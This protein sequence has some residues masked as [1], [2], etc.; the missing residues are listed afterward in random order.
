MDVVVSG[1][2]GFI[3][4][5]LVPALVA[6]GHRARRLVRGTAGEGEVA[7]DPDA[8]TIDVAALEGVEG[9]VHLGGVGIGDKRWTPE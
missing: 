9:V 1:S 6:A 5:A 4:S 7:W 2:H 3:G 8:G